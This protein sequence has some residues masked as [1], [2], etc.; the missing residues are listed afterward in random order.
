LVFLDDREV[1][2]LF[3]RIGPAPNPEYEIGRL[4]NEHGFTRTPALAGALEYLRPGLEAGTLAVVQ[5]MVKHQ[6][7]A[8]EFTIDELR[9]Y[10]ERVAAQVKRSNQRQAP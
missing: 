2:E 9:R 8:W 6:G 4:L 5:A 3:R 1:L 10:Y 7:S